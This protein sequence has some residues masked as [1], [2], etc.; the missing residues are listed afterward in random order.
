MDIVSIETYVEIASEHLPNLFKS[1]VAVLTNKAKDLTRSKSLKH[2]G[3]FKIVL[4]FTF[5]R[6]IKFGESRS[7]KMDENTGFQTLGQVFLTL[8]LTKL[9]E[10][11]LE[12]YV[13]IIGF[14][15]N[16]IRGQSSAEKYETSFLREELEHIGIHGI[17]GE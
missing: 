10:V 12:F 16:G 9:E 8:A 17:T 11:A 3:I 15:Y 4:S 5:F 1:I 13:N 6:E 7:I 14:S 2:C